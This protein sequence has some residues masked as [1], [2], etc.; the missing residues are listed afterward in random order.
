LATPST[1]YY[2]FA[3]SYRDLEE[4]LALRGIRVS[5]ET[6]RRWFL[7][8]GPHFAAEIRRRR[9]APRDRWHLD[10]M[11]LRTGG[12]TYYLWRAVDADGMVLDIV[13]QE[14]RNQAAA[15]TLLGH[16]VEGQP[17]DPRTLVI[18]KLASHVLAIRNV[19]PHA[20]HR[21]HLGLNNRAE[22]SH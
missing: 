4:I 15:E 18:D 19:F 1:Y 21:A 16:L 11:H 2:R 13:L 7:K 20:E 17:T 9:P 14:R 8:F 5:Y 6:I 3:V 10:E 12:R 22:N